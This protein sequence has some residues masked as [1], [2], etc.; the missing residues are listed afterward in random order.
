MKLKLPVYILKD[1]LKDIFVLVE[2]YETKSGYS[3]HA[4][5][6]SKLILK[7]K[8]TN[9]KLEKIIQKHFKLSL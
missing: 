6:V 4:K 3:I 8:H 5:G 2:V 7:S 9:S 1:K